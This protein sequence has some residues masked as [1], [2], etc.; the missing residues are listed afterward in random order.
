MIL[1]LV[2]NLKLRG[3]RMIYIF[4]SSSRVSSLSLESLKEQ[5]RPSMKTFCI[6]KTGIYKYLYARFHSFRLS[7]SFL[8]MFL[9]PN[10]SEICCC[11]E[12]EMRIV[13]ETTNARVA[14]YSLMSLGICIMV[15]LAQIWHLKRYFQKKKLI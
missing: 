9:Y 12:A 14:W 15:S 5:L 1:L 2:T 6:L 13:S 4:C 3:Y 11:R 8:V 7:D 10:S